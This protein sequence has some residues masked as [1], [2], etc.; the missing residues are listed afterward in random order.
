MEVCKHLFQTGNRDIPEKYLKAK[1]NTANPTAPI[2]NVYNAVESVD[3][4]VY[5]FICFILVESKNI[6]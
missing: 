4:L 3:V 6:P 2:S 5:L 1:L